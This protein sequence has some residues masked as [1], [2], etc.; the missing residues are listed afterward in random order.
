MDKS[1]M[2]KLPSCALFQGI[3][4]EELHGMLQ[5]LNPK[6]NHYKKNEYIAIAGETFE[7]IGILLSGTAVVTKEDVAGNRMIISLLETGG[8]FGEMAAFSS[9]QRHWPATVVAQDACTVMFLSPHKMIGTCEKICSSHRLLT[10]NLHQI[11]SDKAI[12]L[13]KKLEYLAIKSI[14][15]K[16]STFLLEQ[17]KK[18]G[19]RMFIMPMKR[20]ELADFL[21]VTRPSLSREMCKM[22]DEGLIDFYR[23]SIHLKDIEGLKRIVQRSL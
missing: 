20:N 23:A 21:N 13:N 8:M 22:R 15:G 5:C 7:G 10:M 9:K 4:M 18:N 12:L 14:R 2:E 6:V 19:S 16:L 1:Q 11:I 3:S 17:Y